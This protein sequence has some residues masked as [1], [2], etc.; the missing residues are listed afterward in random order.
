MLSGDEYTDLQMISTYRTVQQM[1]TDKIRRAI[2][3]G[4]LKPNTRLNQSK[5]ASQLGVSRIPTR[6]ALRILEAERL[7]RFQAHRG[8]MVAAMSPTDIM[9]VYEI[10]IRLE[11]RAALRAVTRIS[12]DQLLAVKKL[13]RRMEQT[14]NVDAWVRLN[15]QFHLGI[16]AATG[17]SRFLTIVEMMRNLTAPYVYMYVADLAD[18]SIANKEHALL[19]RALEQ[20][21]PALMKKVLRAHLGHV[22]DGIMARLVLKAEPGLKDLRRAAA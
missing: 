15:N 12:P 20:R 10:L 9:E 21:R 11:T 6:E 1:V 14:T 8:A 16:Y 22:R 18:R 5:L 13:H 19:I 7:I 2:L 4:T 17:C 3:D